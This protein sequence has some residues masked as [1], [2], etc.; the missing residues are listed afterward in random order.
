MSNPLSAHHVPQT[1]VSPSEYA[2]QSHHYITSNNTLL[3]LPGD[4]VL[5]VNFT[6][7]NVSNFEMYARQISTADNFTASGSRI[8]V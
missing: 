7:E 2:Q 8:V 6:V 5:S 4:H 1:P 3:S